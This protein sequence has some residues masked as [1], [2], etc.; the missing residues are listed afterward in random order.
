MNTNRIREPLQP[1]VAVE[2]RQRPTWF[3][4][5]VGAQFPDLADLADN[6]YVGDLLKAGWREGNARAACRKCLKMQ[7]VTLGCHLAERRQG[8]ENLW[9]VRGPYRDH[10]PQHLLLMGGTGFDSRSALFAMRPASSGLFSQSVEVNRGFFP[11]ARPACFGGPG[12]M[13]RDGSTTVA[14][15]GKTGHGKAGE[16]ALLD[17][18]PTATSR[19]LS[20]GALTPAGDSNRRTPRRPRG[21]AAR[22]R[23]SPGN[24]RVD[25]QPVEPVPASRPATARSWADL[26]PP[27]RFPKDSSSVPF[28]LGMQ[29]PQ[30]KSLR[31]RARH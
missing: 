16:A 13:S 20:P 12:R 30:E 28:V 22:F 26:L 27:L 3:L 21:V 1:Q 31:V 9:V 11:P 10:S 7:P 25:S 6:C 2:Q 14:L 4:R 19:E 8:L 23:F 18:A 29:T 15:P 17:P 5:M 24:V